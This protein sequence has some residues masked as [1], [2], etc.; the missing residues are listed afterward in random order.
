MA[1]RILAGAGA[2][3]GVLILALLVM[4]L[5]LAGRPVGVD[6]PV[7]RLA[8]PGTV[9]V[10]RLI[11]VTVELRTGA[12]ASCPAAEARPMAV[13]LVV[14]RS[15]SM[16]GA[17]VVQAAQ[18]AHRFA[19]TLDL[20][21]HQAGLLFFN[22]GVSDLQPL[23]QDRAEVDHWPEAMEAVDGTTIAP[24]L[25]AARQELASH[26]RLPGSLGVI[27]L[28]SDGGAHD[29][30]DTLREA[31]AAKAEGTRVVV[32]GLRG[33]DFNEPLLIRLANSPG[34]YRVV[35][36]PSELEPLYSSL[37]QEI[38]LAVATDVEVR[39]PY[40]AAHFEL[41]PASTAPAGE[42]EPGLVLWRLGT[43]GGDG[44]Q[45]HYGL[46]ARHVGWHR[47]S[48]QEGEVT[49]RDCRDAL[50]EWRSPRGPWVL[51]YPPLWWLLLPLFL[52]PL[53]LLG[54]FFGR[55]RHGPT[56]KEPGPGP[57]R[58]LQPLPEYKRRPPSFAWVKEVR[59]LKVA[60]RGPARPPVFPHTLI[61]GIGDTGRQ[62]LTQVKKN[63][64][65]RFGVMPSGV[66]L[67]L[68]D[69]HLPQHQ[70]RPLTL[71][72]VTLIPDEE[73][74]LTPNLQEIDQAIHDHPEKYLHMSWWKG[75]TP[76]DPGRAG[77]RIALFYDLLKGRGESRL[78]RALK[79]SLQDLKEPTVYV[80]A[81]SG[82]ALESGL[83][84]DLPHVMRLAAEPGA[85]A[86]VALLLALP[87]A[88]QGLGDESLLRSYTFATLRELQRLTY[89]K[90]SLFEYNPDA[91]D[92]TLVRLTKTT[93]IDLC[94]LFDGHGEKVDLA[95]IPPERG[96]LAV[97]ADCLTI[98]TE[99]D[100]ASRLAQDL[101]PVLK[102]AGDVQAA[103]GECLVS[104]MGSFV[105][106]LPVADLRRAAEY[107]FLLQ[108]F[109]GVPE[110]AEGVGVARLFAAEGEPLRLDH[111]TGREVKGEPGAAVFSFLKGVGLQNRHPTLG[112]LADAVRGG[113]WE[114]V[115]V[116]ACG[117]LAPELRQVFRWSLQE[118][119]TLILNGELEDPIRSRSGKLAYTL[120][121][122]EALDRTLEEGTHL[123]Q[124]DGVQFTD[125]TVAAALPSLIQEWRAAVERARDEVQAWVTLLIS[126]AEAGEEIPAYRPRR[127]RRKEVRRAVPALYS[128]LD[129]GWQE[130]RAVL[131]QARQVRMRHPL[132]GEDLEKP[133][134]DRWMGMI[135]PEG[136]GQ[137]APLARV[138]QRI[139]WWWEPDREELRLL[140]LPVEYDGRAGEVESY[141]LRRDQLAE[142]T[143]RLRELAQAFS[144]ALLDEKLK[145]H[146]DALGLE[147]VTTLL[148]EGSAPLVRYD[149]TAAS[150]VVQ[151]QSRRYLV[152]ADQT[153]GREMAQ[154]ISDEVEASVQWQPTADPYTCAV[155]GMHDLLP[156]ST[157]G[158]YAEA[159]VEYYSSPLLHVFPAE[160]AAVE[161]ERELR[162]AG[163]TFHP[164]FARLL[165]RERPAE[166]FGLSY[167]YGLV[168]QEGGR[169]LIRAEKP[170]LQIPLGADTL[171]EAMEAF[172]L[173]LPRTAGDDHPLGRRNWRET[174]AQIEQAVAAQCEQMGAN[175][176]RYLE[177]FLIR[178]AEPLE[179]SPKPWERDLGAFLRLLV[180]DEKMQ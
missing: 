65:D 137:V 86:R 73:V 151:S 101:S 47:V 41:N 75:N 52:I 29:P 25:Q 99:S 130:A 27:V 70:P 45:L 113:R 2:A 79:R 76:E 144:Q 16:T 84:L 39:E 102:T 55:R 147:T 64:S 121:F 105:C 30:E 106:R 175:R 85:V 104:N 115:A 178:R 171:L 179:Q 107:R 111:A 169:Y 80:V 83:V 176:Y 122:L 136:A 50:V 94:Y 4:A 77:G 148:A 100:M 170:P 17:P 160:Q 81:S 157:L 97:M 123:I 34:D 168:L 72:G 125:Q 120:D 62:V 98:I 71:G 158:A 95:G 124:R 128:E 37:A 149:T 177:Q 92:E 38:N 10:G 28:L 135:P 116:V 44:R 119:L 127:R 56:G 36:D 21:Q 9:L 129:Q 23:T 66:R 5:L 3:L 58:G 112:A 33:A 166:L 161:R 1:K 6:G 126:Q 54:L 118:K 180:E 90:P 59:S 131:E 110:A 154:R 150:K 67:L 35:A 20:A 91:G 89:K 60:E 156:L 88:F 69:A 143:C 162:R 142:I 32:V 87:S 11:S 57:R 78:W 134:G 139:G 61:V 7:G 26:R 46:L 155:V 141:A 167:I 74:I 18:A 145:R 12:L 108:L 22:G 82:D 43:L 140:I 117:P 132:L 133:F 114:E 14:D 15:E 51:V 172:A 53:A 13:M 40:D 96:V 159:Q 49:M 165:E 103:T 42:V 31:D 174:V 48:P 24:A 109:F 138:M 19:E 153:D 68:V 164:L 63:L 146:L 93:P 8:A 152:M 173:T 163:W